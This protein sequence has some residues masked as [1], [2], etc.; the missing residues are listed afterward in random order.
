MFHFPIGDAMYFVSKSTTYY[1]NFPNYYN[2]NSS[3]ASEI[4]VPKQQTNIG[5]NAKGFKGV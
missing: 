4:G 2:K 3:P 5:S 1:I